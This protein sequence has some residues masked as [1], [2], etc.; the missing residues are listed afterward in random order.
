MGVVRINSPSIR[1][2]AG[3]AKFMPAY[4]LLR[5]MAQVGSKI[6]GWL[7]SFILVMNTIKIMYWNYIR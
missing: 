1:Y 3:Q 7:H 6:S 2:N 4:S 5:K